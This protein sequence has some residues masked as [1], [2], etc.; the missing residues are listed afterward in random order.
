MAPAAL[1]MPV[2]D[3]NRSAA[4]LEPDV[5]A[6]AARPFCHLGLFGTHGHDTFRWFVSI[7]A[8]RSARTVL[9]LAS[10]VQLDL[11]LK[12]Y[13][14]QRFVDY[15]RM[16]LGKQLLGR[17]RQLTPPAPGWSFHQYTLGKES[18]DD[19]AIG[20]NR[21]LGMGKCSLHMERLRGGETKS[22]VM[23]PP[24]RSWICSPGTA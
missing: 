22:G 11:G 13:P 5:A 3:I 4:I 17:A 21:S 6:H 16:I 10:A 19:G 24:E 14:R 12:G 18:L 7:K 23:S 20:L 1:A 2:H 15:Q 9:T 8:M